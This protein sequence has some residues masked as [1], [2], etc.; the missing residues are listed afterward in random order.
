MKNV[1]TV[2]IKCNAEKLSELLDL[3]DVDF[4][5]EIIIT[6]TPQEFTHDEFKLDELLDEFELDELLDDSFKLDSLLDDD[7][8]DDSLL[9]E[10]LEFEWDN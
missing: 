8:E 7:F 10:D 6:K 5:Q 1:R 3:L 9:E 2:T 4:V